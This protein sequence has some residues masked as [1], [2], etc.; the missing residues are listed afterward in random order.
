MIPR[1]GRQKKLSTF[2]K[3]AIMDPPG[4]ITVQISPPERFG[5]PRAIICDRGTHFC[6]DQF[7]K[8]LLKYGSLS[9]STRIST[10]KV[11]SV[12]IPIG[13][14][15]VHTLVYGNGTVSA[16]EL[17]ARKLIGLNMLTFDLKTGRDQRKVQ[18]NELVN[19]VDQAYDIL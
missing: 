16:I 1:F 3:L 5:A 19:C 2:S 18:L 9:F 11:G 7:A 6:N 4:D 13:C 17:E 12:Q 10:D 14:N 8:V 15:S